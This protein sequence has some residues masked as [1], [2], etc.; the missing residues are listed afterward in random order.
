VVA[1]PH[2]LLLDEPLSNLDAKVREQARFWLREFQQR[3]GITTAYVTHDQA[4]ALAISDMVAVMSA[5]RVLQY[6]PPR[7]IY[8]RPASRFVADFI[9]QTS[10]LTATVVET[11]GGSVHARLASGE[12]ITALTDRTWQP[13]ERVLLAIRAE[14]IRFVTDGNAATDGGN[15]IAA[16]IRSFV[17]V[18][19]AYEYLLDTMAGALRAESPDAVAGPTVKLYCPPDSIVVLPDEPEPEAGEGDQIRAAAP[20]ADARVPVVTTPAP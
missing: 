5:G 9:G 11:S 15:V 4:E 16:T 12:V 10:F 20:Q 17:Y 14:R 13:R 2:V 3:L 6:A 1:Q 7:E 8:E 19:T 18:G